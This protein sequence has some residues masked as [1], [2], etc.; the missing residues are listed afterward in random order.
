VTR[1]PRPNGPLAAR[2]YVTNAREREQRLDAAM[3]QI[4]TTI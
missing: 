2:Q 3:K 1:A 4:Q